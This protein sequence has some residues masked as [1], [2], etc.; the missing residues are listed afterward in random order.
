MKTTTALIALMLMLG[1]MANAQEIETTLKSNTLEW[2]YITKTE[3]Q[4]TAEKI[5]ASAAE[6]ANHIEAM[7]TIMHGKI[8]GAKDPQAILDAYGTAASKVLADYAALYQAVKA[9]NPETKVPAPD[10]TV[11]VPKPDGTV[12]Y[13]A[14]PKP[15]PE[16]APPLNP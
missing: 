12:T 6:L 4:A 13:V 8:A 14:P 11:F 7:L 10:L 15:E 16:P 1:C 9:I 5:Q 3:A 2:K